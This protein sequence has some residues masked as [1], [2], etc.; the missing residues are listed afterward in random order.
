MGGQLKKKA[1]LLAGDSLAIPGVTVI[2]RRDPFDL[3]Q[4]KPFLDPLRNISAVEGEAA[5]AGD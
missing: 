1:V 4:L 5:H 2:N 3:E